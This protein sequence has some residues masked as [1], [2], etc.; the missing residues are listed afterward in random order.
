MINRLVVTISAIVAV[1]VI[2]A[3][4][5]HAEAPACTGDRHYDGV[6]CCPYVDTTTTTIPDQGPR[7]ECP[8]PAPC[9]S[10]TCQDGATVFVDRCPDVVFPNYFRCRHDRRGREHCPIKDHPGRFFKPDRRS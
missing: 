8:D 6:A 9:P 3:C 4:L 5:A 7:V 2:F 1:L 10:V